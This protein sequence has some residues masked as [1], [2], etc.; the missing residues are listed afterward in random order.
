MHGF[1]GRGILD[2][3][4]HLVAIDDG[5]RCGGQIDAHLK[6]RFV[7]QRDRKIAVMRLD[8]PHKIFKT[9][10]QT[11]TVGF[12]STLQ[13]IGV[14]GQKIGRRKHVDDLAGE[15]ICPPAICRI[16][17]FQ[18]CNR[19][20]DRFG[21]HQVL[22]FDVVKERMRF[23]QWIAKATVFRR[24]I[25]GGLEFARRQ[26]LL[27]IDVMLQAFA[28]KA[29]LLFDNLCRVLHHVSHIGRGCFH[30]DRLIGAIKRLISLLA[31]RHGSD[32][33]LRQ[34]FYFRKISVQNV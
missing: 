34:S 28:P 33:A 13:R 14:G 18:C 9:L 20:G 27:R 8:I 12:N 15:V 11:C 1:S 10:H 5:P 3:F 29:D 25:S 16:K 22:L 17:R 24:R 31:L 6:G 26:R 21:I 19:S 2:K 23:P 4:Q 30:I 32:H 7:G